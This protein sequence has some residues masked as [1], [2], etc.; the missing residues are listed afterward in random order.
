MLLFLPSP[1][2]CSERNWRRRKKGAW[3]RRKERKGKEES[4]DE[5]EFRM[6]RAEEAIA[7]PA[8]TGP[9][10]AGHATVD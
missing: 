9:L 8:G 6:V 2:D 7:I 1:V 3:R 5:D 10:V 4:R